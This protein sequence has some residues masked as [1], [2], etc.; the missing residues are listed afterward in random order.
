[1]LGE[2]G[3]MIKATHQARGNEVLELLST[4]F[5]PSKNSHPPVTEEFVV[6]LR[7][8]DP[9]AFKKYFSDFVRG[10]NQAPT[11]SS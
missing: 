8:L 3:T 6:K 4:T 11:M 1:M 7:D 9:K 5:L 10:A 2:I